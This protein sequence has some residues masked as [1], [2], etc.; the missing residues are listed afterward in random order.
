[1]DEEVRNARN[2]YRREYKDPQYARNRRHRFE[3]VHGRCE[4]C[5][6]V[7]QPGDW[8]CDHLVPLSKGGTSDISNLR[9]LCIPCHKAK[10]AEDR[11]R[12]TGD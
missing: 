4:L 6:I 3:R 8:Q 10:T 5:S 1:M 7:L 2:P 12:R 9:I 11:R